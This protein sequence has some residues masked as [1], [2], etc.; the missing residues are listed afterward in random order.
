[1]ATSVVLCYEYFHCVVAV[2]SMLLFLHVLSEI[3]ADMLSNQ[4]A[5]YIYICLCSLCIQLFSQFARSFMMQLR[6]VKLMHVFSA[7][8]TVVF[9]WNYCL[10]REVLWPLSATVHKRLSS[11][12]AEIAKS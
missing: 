1:M 7:F 8:A 10:N 2:C 3:V 12:R 4:I 9:I 6:V 5:A 11:E